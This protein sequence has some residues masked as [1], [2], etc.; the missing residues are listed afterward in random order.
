MKSSNYSKK[1]S[2]NWDRNEKF[3]KFDDD[4]Q[5]G[6]DEEQEPPLQQNVEDST[7]EDERVQ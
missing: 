6:E 2:L 1:S 5:E 4:E 7:D 3:F